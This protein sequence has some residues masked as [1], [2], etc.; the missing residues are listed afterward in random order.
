MNRFNIDKNIYL[1][2]NINKHKRSIIFCQSNNTNNTNDNF[3]DLI[4]INTLNTSM[5][6]D[7][8]IDYCNNEDVKKN[9]IIC[10]KI[11]FTG[12]DISKYNTIISNFKSL[13]EQIVKPKMII[14]FT[15]NT[16]DKIISSQFEKIQK[17]DPNIFIIKHIQ[18][19][20]STKEI[21]KHLDKFNFLQTDHIIF[22]NKIGNI[23]YNQKR[24]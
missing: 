14:V 7:N 15:N 24:D 11:D 4:K 23:F 3:N 18:N 10:C 1:L 16:S 20:N 2:N 22:V 12:Y 5:M 17:L 13:Y 19:I 9:I 21:F 8:S 6:I